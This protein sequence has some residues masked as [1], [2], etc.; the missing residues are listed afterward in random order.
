MCGTLGIQWWPKS[1]LSP[2][3]LFRWHTDR[4]QIHKQ[5]SKT[6]TAKFL[7][8]NH[9]WVEMETIARATCFRSSSQEEKTF[10]LEEYEVS[11][12]VWEEK[13]CRQRSLWMRSLWDGEKCLV[14]L[15]N[16]KKS[17]II[18]VGRARERGCDTRSS[19]DQGLDHTA[20]W[21]MVRSMDLF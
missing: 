13:H 17:S 9:L 4:G 5:T 1:Q 7:K 11:H 8:R 15:R 12:Y 6:I 18:G 14:Q 10:T 2:C 3:V 19:G 16:W 20:L 21:T